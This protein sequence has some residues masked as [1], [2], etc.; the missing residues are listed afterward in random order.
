MKMPWAFF[1]ALLTGF[2]VWPESEKTQSS[3]GGDSK[4]KT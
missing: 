1:V 2:A 3:T 4:E